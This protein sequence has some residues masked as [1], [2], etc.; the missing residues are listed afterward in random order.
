[1]LTPEETID[2]IARRFGRHP[3]ARALHAK[4]ILATGS[5]VATT[6]A[7]RLTRAAH[8]RGEPVP[9][10]ARM[11][12]GSGNPNSPD[13]APDVRG[14]AVS[15]S[16]PDGSATDIVAQTAPHFPARNADEFIELMQ[17]NAPGPAQ[18][19]RLPKF[20]LTHPA[21]RRGLPENLAA[22]KPPASFATRHYYAVH[23]YKWIDGEGGERH[24][25]YTWVPEAGQ[26]SIS[27]GEAKAAGRDYLQED[28]AQRL[29][30]G[31]VRFTL[32]LQIAAEDDPVD[33]PTAEWPA[34]RETVDAGTLELTA[35]ETGRETGGEL[36]V[37]DP[38]RITDG[39]ELTDDPV[40]QFRPKAYSVSI[41]RRVASAPTEAP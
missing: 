2:A 31:P 3:G 19:W 10:L 30:Q 5:F 41:E 32:R 15:F 27:K 39:I 23:A 14:L 1:M 20:L 36:L 16:L 11:S 21:A 26:L 4:G 8:M 9:V 18:L 24:V 37:F 25:R 13:Y 38:A 29:A 33:D 34:D 17:A 28:I 35:I 40:L 6:D 12:N 22:L 7:G